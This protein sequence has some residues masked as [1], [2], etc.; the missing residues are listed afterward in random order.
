MP[1]TL[2]LVSFDGIPASV[3]TNLILELQERLA[4]IEAAGGL[5]LAGLKAGDRVRIV[6]GPFAGYEAIFDMH[7]AWQ[8]TGS[9]FYWPFLADTHSL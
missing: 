7:S 4:E 3:P 9:K 5:E 8:V 6:E 2:G 1:G